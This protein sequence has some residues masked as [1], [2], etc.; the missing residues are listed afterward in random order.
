M[1]RAILPEGQIVCERY[2][3]VEEGVELY[4][5]NDQFV[6]FVPYN[7]LHALVDEDT[8]LGDDRSIM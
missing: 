1:F 5:E 2:D 7:N 3:Q 6:A 4:D 8:Y